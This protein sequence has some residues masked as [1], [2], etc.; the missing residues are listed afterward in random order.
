MS[1]QKNGESLIPETF[2]TKS[3]VEKSNLQAGWWSIT[4]GTYHH[5]APAG[6]KNSPGIGKAEEWL[7][8]EAIIFP[9]DKGLVLVIGRAAELKID[10]DL[11]SFADFMTSY[12]DVV[13]AVEG[14]ELDQVADFGDLRI[15]RHHLQISYHPSGVVV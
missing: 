5:E 10:A 2:P 13:E 3:G 1:E 12:K 9:K 6:I 4:D 8:G 14:E 11:Q 15:S 7:S